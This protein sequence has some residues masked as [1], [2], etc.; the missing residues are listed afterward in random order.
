MTYV[1]GAAHERRSVD[2][3]PKHSQQVLWGSL[4]LEALGH[5]PCE[6]LKAL[7]RVAPRQ[8]FIGPAQPV[9]TE[10]APW[11]LGERGEL[12]HQRVRGGKGRTPCPRP[13]LSPRFQLPH[14]CQ[15]LGRFGASPVPWLRALT[16]H[17]P[18]PGGH[19]RT[20]CA[21]L[22]AQTTACHS[23]WVAGHPPPR[24][25]TAQTAKSVGSKGGLSGP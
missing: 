6:V 24:L 8:R 20:Q 4:Q 22:S 10:R 9:G 13:R 7:H 23:W 17:T 16:W 12:G 21:R 3:L 19:S 18:S 1:D 5:A 2:G 14:R 11:A 25:P 15:G